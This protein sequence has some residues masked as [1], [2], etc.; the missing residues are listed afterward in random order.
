MQDNTNANLIPFDY[1]VS[2]G[3]LLASASV[4]VPLTLQADSW[5]EWHYIA[6]TGTLD[7]TTDFS[8]NNF[9][10]LISDQSTGRALANFRIPQRVL[11]MPANM[12]MRLLRPILLPPAANLLFDILN[13]SG[14]S[15]NTVSLVL[16]GFKVFSQIQG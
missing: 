1:L 14:G 10:V 5:F 3:V 2:S 15:S 9:S 13:L 7:N 4:I 12:G 6:G 16:R 11:V 8:P